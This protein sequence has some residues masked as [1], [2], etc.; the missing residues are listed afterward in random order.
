L[1][2]CALKNF[3]GEG[4]NFLHPIRHS[5]PEGKTMKRIILISSLL[6]LSSIWAAAQYEAQPDTSQSSSDS[7]KMTVQGCLSGSAGSYSLMDK[8]GATYQLTGDTAKLQAH[9]GH[10]IQVTGTNS[11]SGSSSGTMGKPVGSMSTPAD[12]QPTL[13]VTSFKH[14]SPSCDAAH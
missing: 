4:C 11:A 8:S 7:N 3:S 1:Q 10:T 12:S 13:S 9:V 5:I 6:L 2:K 14:V